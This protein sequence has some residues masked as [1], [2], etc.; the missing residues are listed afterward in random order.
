MTEFDDFRIV[1][2]NKGMSNVKAE[3]RE[4]CNITLII[5]III[6]T[7]AIIINFCCIAPSKQEVQLK[8]FY[9]QV[10]HIKKTEHKNRH[11]K[12]K[13]YLN[14]KLNFNFNKPLNSNRKINLKI[15]Y[16]EA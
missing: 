1:G 6:I 10:F 11:R 16:T 5:T 14:F 8:V 13:L 2:T 9:N 12:L 7:I 15:Q 3:T 4:L